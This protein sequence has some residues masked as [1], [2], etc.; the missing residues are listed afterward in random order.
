LCFIAAFSSRGRCV[1]GVAV[2]L[3]L[4]CIGC[5]CERT[6]DFLCLDEGICISLQDVC[7]LDCIELGEVSYCPSKS[8]HS[9]IDGTSLNV[10]IQNQC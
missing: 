1:S 2:N 8:M 4:S 10:E 9:K 3:M 6:L 7:K 5:I